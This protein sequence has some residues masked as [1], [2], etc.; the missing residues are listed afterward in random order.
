MTNI[1]TINW[2]ATT[3]TFRAAFS[4][5]F[6]EPDSHGNA[7]SFWTCKPAWPADQSEPAELTEFIRELH[8]EELPNDWRYATIVGILD[9]LMELKGEDICWED[10]VNTIADDLTSIYTSELA[11]WIAE[12]GSRAS[13][14]DEAIIDGLINDGA[15]LWQRLAIAQAECIRS[16]AYR[17]V[18]KLKLI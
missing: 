5:E 4:E 14:H 6:R 13:Y 18:Q 1:Q 10:E 11:A 7:S 16:M 15:T 3:G 12:N 8:D 9:A 17:I 2:F